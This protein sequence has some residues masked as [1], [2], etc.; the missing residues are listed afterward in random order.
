MQEA[1]YNIK[2]KDS[3][4]LETVENKTIDYNRK[5]VYE[6]YLSQSEGIINT[7]MFSELTNI[8]AVR[9]KTTKTILLNTEIG[10]VQTTEFLS[11]PGFKIF[12]IETTGN[13]VLVHIIVYA[14][15]PDGEETEIT[16]YL[17]SYVSSK[18]YSMNDL[19]FLSGVIYKSLQN[20]NTNH[21]PSIS[22]T[23]WQNILTWG[24]ITGN[25]VNQTDLN[26]ALNGKQD[27]FTVIDGGNA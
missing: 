10:T 22:P 27:V 5:I 11:L 26:S 23:Y 18:I 8:V 2:I 4:M 7:P 20:N 24:N 25:I 6:R 16:H 17:N 19:C 15:I 1:V 12:S 13:A 9:I 21:S 14:I 3:I